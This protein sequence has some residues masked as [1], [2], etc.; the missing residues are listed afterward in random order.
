M[1]EE[2][3]QYYLPEGLPVPRAQRTGLDKEYWDAAKRH[4]LVVQ[5]C[6]SCSAFQWGPELICH[7]CH[8]FD[9]G[10]RKVSG[11]GRLYSWV[12][13]WNPVHPALRGAC[14][15]IVAVVELPD[16]GKVRMV[17]NLL[18][19]PMQSPLFDSDVEAVFEDHPEA[20]LVQ[21]R[22]LKK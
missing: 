11:R 4:E 22:L 16:A 17:G 10:W 1:P 6:N 21:W 12:R 7:A 8:G 9:L 3:K 5:C 19:D 14:P 18:C 2:A 15:Y 20:T 13:S